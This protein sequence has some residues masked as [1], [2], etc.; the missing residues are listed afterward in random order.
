MQS[1]AD[2]ILAVDDGYRRSKKCGHASAD[3]G[4]IFS[5]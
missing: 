4:F 1:F 3:I 2:L 5:R